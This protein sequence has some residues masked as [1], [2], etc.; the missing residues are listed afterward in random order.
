MKDNDDCI[1]RGNIDKVVPL[2][3]DLVVLAALRSV[4]ASGNFT[5]WNFWFSVTNQRVLP[6]RPKV[7]ADICI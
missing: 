3:V 7:P 5:A 2:Q 1:Y 6:F 4:L